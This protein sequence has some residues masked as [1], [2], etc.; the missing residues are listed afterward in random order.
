MTFNLI[1]QPWIPVRTV[2]GLRKSI[3]PWEITD[4]Y[5]QDPIVALEAPRADFRG[6]LIQFLI[7]LVQTAAAPRDHGEWLS[8][9]HNPPRPEDLRSA[10]SSI[11]HAFDLDG[12]GPRFMQDLELS[13]GQ[14]K[15]VE[16]LLIE[17]PGEKTVRDNTD[18]FIKA[19]SVAGLCRECCATALFTLQTN[20]PS[21]GVGHRTSLR[22]GGPLT[23]LV[24]GN[25]D[26][27]WQTVWLNTLTL[28]TFL[29]CTGPSPQNMKDE[30]QFPWLAPTR[31]SEPDRGGTTRPEDV[32]PS[33]VFWGMPRRI[34]LDF[35]TARS[36]SCDLCRAVTDN[37][38]QRYFTK[39]YGVNYEGS[40]RHPLTPHFSD[41]NGARLPRHAQPGGVSYRHWLGLVQEDAENIAEPA[42]VVHEFRTLRQLGGLNSRLW[43]FGYDMDNMKARCWYESII[44]LPG[45]IKEVRENYDYEIARFI[46]AAEQVARNLR[47]S[48]KKGWFERPSDVQGDFGFLDEKFWHATQSDFYAIC[49]DL[50]NALESTGGASLLRLRWHQFLCRTALC[51]FEELVAGGPIQYANPKRV[52][53]ARNDLDKWNRGKK[54]TG[55]LDLPR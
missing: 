22:G 6:A 28:P 35:S 45:I 15:G 30:D 48:V 25:Q 50:K 26:Q 7:G 17:F 9:W 19:G 52:A 47:S 16:A 42:Y 13:K 2:S 12:G 33:Q 3:A 44:P 5:A 43:A 34:R 31:T 24:I 32:H 53:L 54:I 41:K 49:V 8:G 51:I 18:H 55:I 36:G 1:E 23:T 46:R 38:V 10:F 40:W 39:N 20:A 4:R 11:A 27:L 37:L 29:N 21:G 14:G